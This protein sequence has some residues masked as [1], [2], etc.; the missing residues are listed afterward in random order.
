VVLM[1]LA[2][3]DDRM[4]APDEKFHLPNLY[5]G[6]EASIRFLQRV[7]RMAPRR[8]GRPGPCARRR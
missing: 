2:L 4:H 6:I 8:R 1:G 3:P 5:R 7:G